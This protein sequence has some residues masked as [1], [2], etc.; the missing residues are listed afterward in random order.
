M[1]ANHLNDS[2]FAISDVTTCDFSDLDLLTNSGV[3]NRIGKEPNDRLLKF[4]E[5]GMGIQQRY[6][7]TEK[8][9]AYTLAHS[10]L[11]QLV[12]RNETILENADFVIYAGISN[13]FPVTT[14]SARLAGE[15]GFKN[16]SCWDIKSGCST[17]LLAMQQAISLLK[18]GATN[19]VIVASENLSRFS[20]PDIL[21]MAMAIGD[22]AVALHITNEKQWQVKS[23][24]H[25]TDST[26][27]SYMRV[28]GEFPIIPTDYDQSNYYFSFS[29]KPEG[30]E[31]LSFYWQSSLDELLKSANIKGE[32][33]SHYVAHQVDESKNKAISQSAN[34]PTNNV[35]LNFSHFGNMGCPTIFINYKNW[36]EKP[37]TSFKKNDYLVFHAVGGGISWA[38]ICAQHL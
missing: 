17:A 36:I 18:A 20:N 3:M 12:K 21:Q 25:G 16:A 22:G 32:D 33:I 26:Y 9:N 5:S 1:L 19:G 7:C 24:T 27:S 11:S 30:I 14:L 4:I 8:Q 34:I 2:C 13:P 37:S 10:A 28:N 23:C 35:A 6:W 31:K 29:N 38:G 15:L